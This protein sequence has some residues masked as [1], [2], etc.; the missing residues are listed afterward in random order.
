MTREAGLYDARLEI[1]LALA[2]FRLGQLPD[3][4]QEAVRLSSAS[5]RA[6]LALAELWHALG[7][8]ERAAGHARAAYRW[9]WADGEP[10]V[11]A[12]EL[13]RATDLLN[14]LG[15]EIPVLPAYDP[16]QDPPLAFEGEVRAV[17]EELREERAAR[18]SID[19]AY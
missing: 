3:A 12:Y 19:G 8:A 18:G 5:G 11:H 17:I 15:A 14:Q 9:A 1:L 7:D 10:Y 4:R 16:A 2:W 13:G 6:Q